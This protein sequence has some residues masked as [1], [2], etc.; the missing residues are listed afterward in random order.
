MEFRS[1]AMEK[2]P[3]KNLFISTLNFS[4]WSVDI[5]G[6]RAKT[7][8][9]PRK[10]VRVWP[11]T[12]GRVHKTEERAEW[13]PPGNIKEDYHESSTQHRRNQRLS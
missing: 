1:V 7:L 10:D 8:E 12:G 6:V 5:R 9:T 11:P 13:N 2:P 4:K 3:L